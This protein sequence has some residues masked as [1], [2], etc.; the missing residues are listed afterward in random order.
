MV[1]NA[2]KTAKTHQNYYFSKKPFCR[3]KIFFLVPENDFWPN[4]PLK[5]SKTHQNEI[6][7]YQLQKIFIIK[8][9][10]TTIIRKLCLIITKAQIKKKRSIFILLKYIT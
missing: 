2:P 1:S 4:N 5:M 10:F 7:D 9:K 8:K 3:T 6:L